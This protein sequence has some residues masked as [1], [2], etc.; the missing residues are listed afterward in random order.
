MQKN[1][2]LTQFIFNLLKPYKKYLVTFSLVGLFWAITNTILPYTL[3]IIIDKATEFHDDITHIFTLIQPYIILYIGLWVFFAFN[4][5]MLDYARLKLFPN[6]KRDITSNM[7]SYLNLHSHNYFQN[8]FA[9]SLINKIVDMLGGV[10]TIITIIDDVYAQIL[11]LTIAIITLI[12]VNPVFAVILIIWVIAFMIITFIFLKPI[13]KLSQAFAEARSSLVGKMIDS[14]GNIVNVRLF[15]HHEFENKYIGAVVNDTVQKD[16]NMETRVIWMRCFWDVSIISLLGFNLWVLARMY[17]QG[18][19]TIGDFS[20][21]IS[22]S[23]SIIWNL[24]YIAGQFVTFSELVGKCNQALSI[25]NAQH[26][27]IDALNAK[28][29]IVKKGQIEFKNVSFHYGENLK[30]FQN[31][32]IIINPGEKIGLVGFSGSG[33]STFVNLILRL[34]DVESG[35]I[36]IDAQNIK[37]VT[38]NSLRENIAL[39]PQDISLFH[40]TLIENIRYGLI[41]ATDDDVIN[42]AQKAHC[43]EFIS[44]LEDGYQA[45][46]GERGIKLSGG[47]RQR[48]AI[49]R[50]I[51]KNAPILILDE[52]TSALDSVTEKYIQDALH[53]LMLGKTTIVIAHRLSTLS[54]M[55]RILVFNNGQII[56]DGTHEAL[57]QKQ[58]HYAK[59]W[60]MQAGGFLPDT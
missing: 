12:F 41:D 17:S 53:E 58:G 56:E 54:E 48:I 27:I 23:T 2:S 25:L 15:A 22:L 7:F 1:Y 36:T 38:Q 28:K 40:R 20:F 37:Q 13:Q 55:D 60:Q 44:V 5:R 50:A 26:D 31:K 29:L 33:K 57:L 59:M 16:I 45:M 18:L 9:G 51:L 30:L 6:L 10:V 34:F 43:H 19:V 52:A 49:A 42:A 32:N 3:K 14:I 39:I 24:W 8:N 46:V 21:V 4:M 11:A 35:A 47:Q